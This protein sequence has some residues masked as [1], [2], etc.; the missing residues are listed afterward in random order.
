MAKNIKKLI[1][2]LLSK[3]PSVR[4]TAAEELSDGDERALYPLIKSLSDENVGVQDAA[5]RSLITIGGEVTAYMTLPLMRENTLLRNT[6]LIILKE[7]GEVSV[8]LLYRLLKDKDE[9]VR[10][11]AVDL[12]GEIKTGVDASRLVPSLK[13][14]NA[15]VRASAA[16]TLGLLQYSA[17]TPDLIG[18]LGDEEWV[19]FS[20]LEAIGIL[21]EESA[22][23]VIA[24]LLSEGSEAVRYSAIETLGQ[25]G[26]P[27]AIGFLRAYLLK[28]EGGEKN[29]VINALIRI[30]ITPDMADLSD[31][32]LT[33]LKGGDWD[34]RVIALKGIRALNCAEAVPLIVD[35]A[36]SMDPSQ[37][38]NEEKITI[39]K[40]TVRA[41]DSEEKLLELLDSPDVKFRGKAFT[42]E[43]LGEMQSSKALDRLLL[44]LNDMR[45]DLRKASAEALGKIQ[46]PGSV[47][48]LLHTS[49]QDVDAH[50]RRAAIDA[51]GNIRSADAVAPLMEL[52]DLESFYD[53]MERIVNA[54]VKIEPEGFL[55]G[56]VTY[57]EPVREIIAKNWDSL[58]VLLK[59]CDDGSKKVKLA[60]MNGLGRVRTQEALFKISS[61]LSDEDADIRRAAV[62]SLGDAGYCSPELINTLNDSD[63]WVRFYTIKAVSNSCDREKSLEMISGRLNDEFIPVV[64]SAIDA[65]AE[66]GGRE[67]YEVL[68]ANAEHDNPDVRDKIREVMLTL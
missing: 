4:R 41:M 20:A 31:H 27:K 64:M 42:I 59:L 21:K 7:L 29:E 8:P 3:D 28:A 36:G 16:K 33:M 67:A 26:S 44:Y 58:D 45:R 18:A 25:L 24:G 48:P 56:A 37:P 66:I 51:L 61:F 52:L 57:K 34:D 30:G 65:I 1:S 62:I 12:F 39:L 22:V 55:S 17:A 47:A 43:L 6:A 9:D 11:F 60:A 50:V 54:L 40:D 23:D 13:D 35:I 63:P 32:L 14:P 15:N 68:A 5:M 49:Q 10:K 2:R 53:V 19:C 46:D 38:D